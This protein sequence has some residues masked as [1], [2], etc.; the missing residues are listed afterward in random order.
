MPNAVSPEWRCHSGEKSP[1][2][3]PVG[4]LNE[5]ATLRSGAAAFGGDTS[6][7]EWNFSPRTC[8]GEK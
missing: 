3:T 8:R 5:G 4:R 1:V 7:R 6:L 2:Q